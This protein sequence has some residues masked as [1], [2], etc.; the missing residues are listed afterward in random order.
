[1]VERYHEHQDTKLMIDIDNIEIILNVASK[2]LE[3]E[4]V[5]QD[6]AI[7]PKRI[8]ALTRDAVLTVFQQYRYQEID[9]NDLKNAISTR[10]QK[11]IICTFDE[12]GKA[13][14]NKKKTIERKLNTQTKLTQNFDNI[15]ASLNQNKQTRNLIENTVIKILEEKNPN[16]IGKRKSRILMRRKE[17][18]LN[19]NLLYKLED[20]ILI[21]SIASHLLEWILNKSCFFDQVDSLIVLSRVYQKRSDDYIVETI[22]KY[23]KDE[24]I[25]YLARTEQDIKIAID[26]KYRSLI[27]FIKENKTELIEEFLKVFDYKYVIEDR[28]TSENSYSTNENYLEH[29]LHEWDTVLIKNGNVNVKTR[30]LWEKKDYIANKLYAALRARSIDMSESEQKDL[31][32]SAIQIIGENLASIDMEKGNI[33]THINNYI[34]HIMYTNVIQNNIV[35]IKN[36]NALIQIKSFIAHWN[37]K[38]PGKNDLTNREIAEEFNMNI[39]IVKALRATIGRNRYIMID[40][41]VDDNAMTKGD[42]I[43]EMHNFETPETII[44][45]RAFIDSLPL[46]EKLITEMRLNGFKDTEIAEMMGLTHQRV[47]QLFDEMK[48][49]ISR[50]ELPIIQKTVKEVEILDDQGFV[51]WLNKYGFSSKDEHQWIKMH[52]GIHPKWL[53]QKMTTSKINKEYFEGDNQN[54]ISLQRI[55]TTI[56]RFKKLISEKSGKSS[57]DFHKVVKI[58]TKIQSLAKARQIYQELSKN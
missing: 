28:T 49:A 13:D 46:K 39:D 36:K 1:M 48:S 51:D 55:K 31:I 56:N 22:R 27:N 33:W 44:N 8:T 19:N 5:K 11:T 52:L 50:F 47:S 21:T 9:L 15:I 25:Q 18:A 58:E 16:A 23:E 43:P 6:I 53:N 45:N 20:P 38:N 29:T 32:N 17:K 12:Q 37:K 4:Y 26:Q 35:P 41:P 40:E 57:Q 30:S 7:L 54:E 3:Q 10:F 24:K 34:T 14:R 2:L 42:I